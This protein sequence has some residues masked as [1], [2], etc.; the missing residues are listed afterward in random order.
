VDLMGE[1]LGQALVAAVHRGLHGWMLAQEVLDPLG[2][3][4]GLVVHAA[5][6]HRPGPQ[7]PALAVGDG[8]GLD[9]VLLAFAGH[10]RPPAGPV[11]PWPSD[12]GLGAV[13]AQLDAWAAA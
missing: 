10:K 12:L 2:L 3:D 6:A 4:G 8:G 9:A 11:G 5:R 1:R 7:G 13:D